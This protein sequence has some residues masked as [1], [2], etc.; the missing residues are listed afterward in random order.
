MNRTSFG[1]NA[2]HNV[3][4]MSDCIFLLLL[5]LCRVNLSYCQ[6]LGLLGGRPLLL[7]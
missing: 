1:G 3:L 2:G 4:N 5:Y 6:L 7:L